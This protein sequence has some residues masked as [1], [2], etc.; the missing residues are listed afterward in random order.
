VEK[1]LSLKVRV[2]FHSHGVSAGLNPYQSRYEASRCHFE[3]AFH[4]LTLNRAVWGIVGCVAGVLVC[5]VVEVPNP[6]SVGS[7]HL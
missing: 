1:Y 4:L 2:S 7:P 3:K 5:R 6:A